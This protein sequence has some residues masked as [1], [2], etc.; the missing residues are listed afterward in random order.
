MEQVGQMN[1]AAFRVPALTTSIVAIS[2][3]HGHSTSIVVIATGWVCEVF[4]RAA[5]PMRVTASLSWVPVSEAT[6]QM[7]VHQTDAL[8]E[9]VHDGRAHEPQAAPPQNG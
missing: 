6:G 9:G 1:V 3:H 2:A 4:M 7:V 5:S 8:H